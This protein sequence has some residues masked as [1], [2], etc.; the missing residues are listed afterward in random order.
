MNIF[1]VMLQVDMRMHGRSP[2]KIPGSVRGDVTN[3]LDNLDPRS[4]N[5]VG[6]SLSSVEHQ[7][8]HTADGQNP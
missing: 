2:I 7:S 6:A 1:Y 4:P 5:N 3:Q 8:W